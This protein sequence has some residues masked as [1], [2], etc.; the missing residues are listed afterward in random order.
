MSNVISFA[1]AR[2]RAAMPSI[3][4]DARW[5]IEANGA[6]AGLIAAI[7]AKMPDTPDEERPY[8]VALAEE[9]GRIQGYAWHV[10]GADEERSAG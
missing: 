4:E 10:P 2:R 3:V 1:E 5:M 9:I 6:R 7:C 8:W